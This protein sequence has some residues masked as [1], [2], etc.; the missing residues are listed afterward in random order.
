MLWALAILL[1][2]L[3][4][5]GF[6]VIHVTSVLIH[7]LIILAVVAVLGNFLRGVGSRRAV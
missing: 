1:L 5:V 3:W 7:L 2:V 6:F 4:A